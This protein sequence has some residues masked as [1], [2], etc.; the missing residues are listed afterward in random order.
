M[1]GPKTLS[2]HERWW[3]PTTTM[4]ASLFLETSRIADGVSARL[5]T[6]LSMAAP[7][8]CAHSLRQELRSRRAASVEPAVPGE[9]AAAS[10]AGDTLCMNTTRV[11]NRSPSSVPWR[12]AGTRSVERSV[13]ATTASP[14]CVRRAT[15]TGTPAASTMRVMS[16]PEAT[17]DPDTTTIAGSTFLASSATT[18]KKFNPTRTAICR[19]NNGST[20]WSL[21]QFNVRFTRPLW[22]LSEDITSSMLL[23]GKSTLARPAGLVTKRTRRS[24]PK[25]FAKT[26]A[27]SSAPPLRLHDPKAKRTA[28]RDWAC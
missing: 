8:A 19:G 13:A 23:C 27:L 24:A 25:A 21:H 3:V 10:R 4:S 6:T 16:S 5:T 28:P 17:S 12:S 11:R 9:S 15:R 7:K 14:D 1:P 20:S 2:T 18:E 26:A 22:R